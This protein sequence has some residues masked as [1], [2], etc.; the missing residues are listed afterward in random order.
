MNFILDTESILKID[1]EKKSKLLYSSDIGFHNTLLMNWINYYSS[2][3]NMSIG[4][5]P[6]KQHN[7]N[8]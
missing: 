5:M 6:H 7:M 3:L 2:I 4:M 1:E 8:L